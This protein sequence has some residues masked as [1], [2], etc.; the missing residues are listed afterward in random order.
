MYSTS[1]GNHTP[2]SRLDFPLWDVKGS[3]TSREGAPSVRI[4]RNTAC[5][6]GC[7]HLELAYD[8]KTVFRRPIKKFPQGLRYFDLYGF[9]GLAYDSHRDVLSLSA[10]GDYYRVE[11]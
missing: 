3:W 1:N 2:D 5:K 6:N 9:I 8:G 4:Y 10:Y 11:D 7:Y